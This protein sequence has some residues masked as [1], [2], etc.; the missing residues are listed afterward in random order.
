MFFID[1]ETTGIGQNAEAWEIAILCTDDNGKWLTSIVQNCKPQTAWEPKA[2]EMSGL[3]DYELNGFKQPKKALEIIF[4][5]IKQN[6][7]PDK[8]NN[9]IVIHNAEYDIRVLNYMCE[10]YGIAERLTD[11]VGYDNVICTMQ[12]L[13]MLKQAG[14]WNKSSALKH[15][16]DLLNIPEYD[17]HRAMQDVETTCWLFFEI[18]RNLR[19][20]GFIDKLKRL[21][22]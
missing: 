21:F 5:F 1:T 10:K 8:W 22:K 18:Q 3:Q 4:K 16:H 20:N 14:R 15:A 6:A 9:K 2:L 13:R 12:A 7:D 11:F 19:K 17:R